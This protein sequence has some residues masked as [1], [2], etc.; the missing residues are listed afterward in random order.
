MN[1]AAM[2]QWLQT[3]SSAIGQPLEMNDQGLLALELQSG[4]VCTI[5][6]DSRAEIVTFHSDLMTF[7]SEQASALSEFAMEK[8]L[9]NLGSYGLTL[10]ID[11]TR[12]VLVASTNVP[13]SLLTEESF[14]ILFERFVS[15][16][17]E[18]HRDF[19]RFNAG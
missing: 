8:N 4:L 6:V 12:S 19:Q 16:V 11:N 15:A 2:N 7:D 1:S 17:E 3:L 5:E 18:N 13:D 9:Y 10:G 14:L